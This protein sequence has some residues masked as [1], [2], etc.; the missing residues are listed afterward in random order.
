MAIGPNFLFEDDNKIKYI[1]S[2]NDPKR[3]AKPKKAQP[4]VSH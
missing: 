2:Y 3:N 1:Y 4:H